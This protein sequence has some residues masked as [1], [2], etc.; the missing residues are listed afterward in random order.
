MHIFNLLNR[1]YTGHAE[2]TLARIC[3]AS[4]RS[5]HSQ[6]RGLKRGFTSSVG[7]P[8]TYPLA[9][10]GIGVYISVVFQRQL[11]TPHSALARARGEG[12]RRPGEGCIGK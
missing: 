12:G 4:V 7:H 9:R 2:P 6:D 10:E 1:H 5:N 11:I 3:Y 8:M